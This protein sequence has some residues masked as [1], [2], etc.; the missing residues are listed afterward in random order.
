VWAERWEAGEST[1]DEGPHESF[2]IEGDCADDTGVR[3]LRW[4]WVL[5]PAGSRRTVRALAPTVRLVTRH[6]AEGPWGGPP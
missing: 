2:V 5:L 6:G 4:S 1:V 3:R